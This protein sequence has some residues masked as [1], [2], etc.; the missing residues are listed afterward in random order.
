MI[1]DEKCFDL[2]REK[3][4]DLSGALDVDTPIAFLALMNDVNKYAE[5]Q[6]KE[7][8]EHGGMPDH[9]WEAEDG[10]TES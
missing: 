9:R 3:V 2:I 4:A 6:E 1:N 7:G 5:E 10:A 8:S